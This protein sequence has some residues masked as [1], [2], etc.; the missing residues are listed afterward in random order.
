MASLMAAV[1]L[2]C[3]PPAFYLTLLTMSD[4]RFCC[5]TVSCN[6][7]GYKKLVRSMKLILEIIL[8][9]LP[10]WQRICLLLLCK[11]FPETFLSP[12]L[13]DVLIVT[14]QLHSLL[15]DTFQHHNTALCSFS[16]FRRSAVICVGG[17][18]HRKWWT[19]S[20][21][22]RKTECAFT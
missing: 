6:L 16:H 13:V 14:C 15:S 8:S 12:M 5:W 10:T 18:S 3:S 2:L 19:F 9:H 4:S 17:H 21:K 20:H 22:T 7:R 1:L 11:I